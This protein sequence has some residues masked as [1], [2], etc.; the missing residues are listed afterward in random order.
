GKF[1][2]VTA[3]VTAKGVEDTALYVYNRLLSLN[4]VGGEPARFGWPPERVH[5]ALAA[6]AAQPG[7]LSPLSTHDTKRSEDVR[8]RLNVLSEL[9]GEWTDRVGRW[10]HLNAPH[11]TEA[12][13]GAVAPDANEEY[14]IYQTLVGAWLGEPDFTVR[15][16]AF[17]KKA[18]CEAKVHSSWINPDPDYE[19]AVAAFVDRLL[20]PGASAEFL[21]DIEEFAKR[22]AY[23]G[24]IN[25]LAQTTIRCTAPGVP[26]T[27]QS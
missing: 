11:R 16:Q 9:P 23:F 21:A 18:L 27:Y 22:V 13:E 12:D 25:S 20:D 7:G 17:V 14:L 15:I 5:K 8:A 6:R 1:P 2:Q 24:R 4:E 3:P 10:M 26:D 19:A